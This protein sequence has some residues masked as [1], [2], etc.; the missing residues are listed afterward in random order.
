M[1]GR[2]GI[3][4]LDSGKLYGPGDYAAYD[5]LPNE[6]YNKLLATFTAARNVLDAQDDYNI[7]RSLLSAQR[8]EEALDRLRAV[9]K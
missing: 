5:R 7:Y 3:C 1:S 6:A 8:L 4:G 2:W 9:L